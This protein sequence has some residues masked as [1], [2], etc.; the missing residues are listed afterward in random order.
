ME[1]DH[2]ESSFVRHEPCPGCGSSD[3]LARYSDGHAHCFACKHYE[4]PDGEST[5]TRPAS[6]SGSTVKALRLQGEIR[7]VRSRGLNEETCKKWGYRVGPYNDSPAHF[8]YYFSDD[9]TPVAAKVR[10]PDKDFVFIGEPKSAGLY[11]QWL[12][13]ERG[14]M[15]VITEGEIDALTVSQLQSN[16][17]PVVSVPTGANGAAKA[18]RKELAWIEGFDKVIFMFDMDE[19]GREAALECAALLTPGKAAI[20]SLPLKDANEMLMAGRGAEVI[21]A[22]WDAKDFRPDGILFG[23]DITLES[24][25]EGDAVGYSTPYPELDDKLGGLRKAELTMLTAGS[26][27]GKSTLAR[28]IA[29]HLHQQ[30]GLTIGNVYLEESTKKTAQGYIAIHNNVA[31]G[32]LRADRTI[33]SQQTWADSL[34]DVINTRQYFY[35]HFGSLDSDNLLNKLRYMAVGLQ[36]DFIVLDHI[37][38]VVSGQDGSGDE[39][40]D[41]DRLLTKLRSLVEETG[42]GVIAIVHLKQPEGK[43]HEEGGRVTLS[44][45][46]GSGSLKQL[47]DN[48]VALERDQQDEDNAHKAI[49]RILKNREFGDVGEADTLEYTRKTGRLLPAA[50]FGD[51][52]QG[53]THASTGTY[54]TDD[55]PF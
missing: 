35:D 16:K 52:S 49:V 32:D 50:M 36:V 20:A 17:W 10:L 29:Y 44:Q 34:R 42:V 27:I 41:I 47:S 55:I 15:L 7:A 18:I 23:G 1:P 31:L 5:G 19:P 54:D 6:P 26:G 14:K 48:V 45:L 11:G 46:R 21:S 3:A 9:R 28:E 2:D 12:W 24:L 38:I 8:A 22:I 53:G 37:S 51:E 30:H 13:R 4:K 25:Q 33:L 43:P 39:R 40:K